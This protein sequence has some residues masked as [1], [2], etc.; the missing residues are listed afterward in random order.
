MS[1]RPRL[2][3][4]A[5]VLALRGGR[6]RRQR[7]PTP[8]FAT[9]DVFVD[10]DMPV[11]AWRVELTERRGACES[12]AS[13]VATTRRSAT[14]RSTTASLGAP[15]QRIVLA[16]F[17]RRR[18]AVAA[19]QSAHRTRA[20]AHDRRGNARSA[21]LV[22]AGTAEGRPIDAQLSLETQPGR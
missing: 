13:S 9:V 7:S 16:S 2:L 6:A 22:A 12:S 1:R 10:S 15:T 8:A 3:H 20:R 21:R 17:S 4:A 5:L 18:S 19:R 11:A 14:R